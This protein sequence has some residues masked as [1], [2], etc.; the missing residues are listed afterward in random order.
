MTTRKR[1][2]R[3]NLSLTQEEYDLLKRKADSLEMT[4]SEFARDVAL[5]K[6][7]KKSIFDKVD[8]QKF[9]ADFGRV[10]NNINQLAKH[11]NMGQ[12]VP[13]EEVT[14]LRKELE[15]LWLFLN[16]AQRKTPTD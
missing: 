14:A 15:R 10:G 1:F 16:E 4:I 12:A 7:L 9:L 8:T 11:A 13:I 3:V 5:E 2:K 6:R